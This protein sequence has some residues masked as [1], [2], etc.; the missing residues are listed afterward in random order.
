MAT[1]PSAPGWFR[2]LTGVVAGCAVLALLGWQFKH[3]LAAGPGWIPVDF[4]A[5]W[6]AG[7]LHAAGHNPY[8]QEAVRA[9][10]T[11]EVSG[12]GEAVIMWNPPWALAV[13]TPFGLLPVPA[14]ASLWM[15][16]ILVLVVLAADLIWRA[17]DGDRKRRWI[18]WLVAITLAPTIYLF[19]YG[20]L[21]AVPF[22]GVAGFL[23]CFKKK[24]YFWAGVFGGLTA[25]KPHLFSLFA[26]GILFE[27][28]RTKEGRTVLFGGLC[29]GA[30]A[31]AVVSL[32]N[33]HVWADYWAASNG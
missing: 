12:V 21:T 10:Q 6:T 19:A 13:V 11:S 33:T 30:V 14:A 4:M 1:G 24:H 2:R 15:L 26:L 22:V 31:T 16:S 18:A 32:P 20:Q 27:A 7:K 5:F 3:M 28:V 9:I 29:L 17:Y 23:A 8:D 25:S